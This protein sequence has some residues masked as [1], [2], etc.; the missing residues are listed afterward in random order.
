M[1][2]GCAV[3]ISLSV[4]LKSIPADAPDS[5][6][7]WYSVNLFDYERDVTT[8][9]VFID[10]SSKKLIISSP[11]SGRSNYNTLRPG[12]S[13]ASNGTWTETRT[14]RY[15]VTAANV[16][17]GIADGMAKFPGKLPGSLPLKA[18]AYCLPGYN[19]E[20][21]ATPNAGAGVNVKRLNISWF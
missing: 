8:D 2:N 16:E 12:S 11:V 6:F 5:K 18:A 19:I 3:Y 21:E 10:L 1:D 7:I 13:L 17:R 9:H 20:L 15:A 4:Y 14:F